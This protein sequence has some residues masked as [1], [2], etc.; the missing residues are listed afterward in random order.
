MN[1]RR[2]LMLGGS[3]V[4]GTAAFLATRR[5]VDSNGHAHDLPR[6]TDGPLVSDEQWNAD[7][8]Y[9]ADN[10]RPL[11][12][13]SWDTELIDLGAGDPILYV[14]ILAH[15]EIVYARQ[16]RDFSRD[17]RALL[18]RRPEA[19]ERPVGIPERVEEVRELLEGLGIERA[20]IV[21][22]GEGAVVASEFAYKYPERCRSLVMV[23]LGMDHKVPPVPLTN[24]LNWALLNL[25]IEGRLLTDRS[26]L[27][28]VVKFLSGPD[29]RLTWD[30]LMAVYRE[31]PDFLAVC[32]YSVT[33][34]VFYHDLRGKA[35][36]LRVPTLL[37]TT[38][39][40][41]R[42]TPADLEELAAALPDCR[43]VH[44]VPQG[45]RFVNYIQGA[46]VNRLIRDFYAE[47]ARDRERLTTETERAPRT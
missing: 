39:E 35:Q 4:A 43:G 45:G 15:V 41:P 25:P 42:A 2:W 24:A 23:N 34:I 27:L 47:L 5:T 40:D 9:I 28:K 26:W 21:G 13:G 14:P 19:T 6:A 7:R 17:H 18:Y 16:L 12:V 29:Q 38:D 33:P 30:Q 46:A 36:R 32:K 22:R 10:L 44:V 31:I 20:H 8:A 1:R 11:R 37:I 3:L